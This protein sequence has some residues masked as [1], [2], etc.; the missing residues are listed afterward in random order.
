MIS[1][2]LLVVAIPAYNEARY[3]ERT[4]AS[5]LSQTWRDFAIL[6]CDNASTDRTGEIGKA[7]AERDPR[8]HYVRHETNIGAV[9]NFNYAL[10]ATDSQFFMWLGA[11]DMIAPEFLERHIGALRNDDRL[12]VSY[13]LTGWIDEQDRLVK[14]TAVSNLAF[15]PR[16]AIT[17]YLASAQRINECTAINN[18]IRRADLNLVRFQNIAGTDHVILSHLLY[19]GPGHCIAEPLYL[20]RE[21]P[22]VREDYMHRMTGEQDLMRDFTAII[23]QYLNDFDQLTR[24]RLSRFWARPILRAI[25]AARFGPKPAGY[26]ARATNKA[27]AIAMEAWLPSGQ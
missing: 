3:L 14:V 21:P 11:H 1:H 19:R 27:F 4:I 8:V 7:A 25:L 15:M 20:R 16:S 6:I 9:G 2:P 23:P 24:Q 12:S 22:S 13:S 17:R 18:V 5:L 26:V 10:D